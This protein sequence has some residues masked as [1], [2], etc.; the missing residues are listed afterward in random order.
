MSLPVANGDSGGNGLNLPFRPRARLLQLLG[1]ELIGSPRLA[2]FELVK[3]AYDADAETVRV[4]LKNIDSPRASIVV[5]DDGEGMTLET[6]R[7][8]WFVPGHDHRARQRA[9]LR[10][11]RRGRLPLGEKGVGRFAAHKLGDRIKLVTRAAGR[12]ECVVSVNWAALIRKKNLSDAK[13]RVTTRDPVVFR[14]TR[15]GTRITV[16][17][18]RESNWTRGEVRRLQRQITSIASPFTRRSDQFETRL[19]V[20]GH[21]DWVAGVPD[22]DALLSRAPWRFQFRFDKGRFDWKYQ[23]RG[24]TG[25]NL[26]PRHAERTKQPLLI[27]PER[28]MDEFGVDQGSRKTKPGRVVGDASLAEGIG[29]VEGRFY[30]FDRDRAVLSRLDESQLI[31]SY[32]DENGGI[33]VYRDGIRVYNYGESGDDWLGLDLRR[34]N[35]PTRNISRNIVI[36]AV[37][38][39]LADSHHL[40]EKTNR[41]GFVENLALGRLKQIVLGALTPMEVERHKDKDS[42]RELTGNVKF[43]KTKRIK[44][45]FKKL[46]TVARK[47]EMSDELKPLID[48]VEQEYNEFR[49]S[50]LRA[51]LSGMGLAMV[52]H[53]I[54]HGV[55]SLCNLI[56]EG[57]K[58]A[59][60]RLRARELAD[61]LGGFTDLLRK[62]TR[63]SNSLSHLIRRVRDINRVRFRKHCVRLECPV[64]ENDVLDVRSNFVFGLALGALNN[65]LDNAFYWL[66]THWPENAS[67]LPGRKIYMNVNLEL[68]DGPAIVV[69]DTGPGFTDEP[70]LLIRPFFSR[71]PEG[72][73]VGLYYAN[74]VMELGEGHLSFPNATQAD[75]PCEF[76][77][78]VVALVFPKQRKT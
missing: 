7:D 3:N 57:G 78:A 71:R 26:E 64:L 72:M 22:V 32:L 12:P 14:G 70:E 25:I 6:I 62:G 53:E 40:K 5:E 15:T 59:A 77:G 65:L 23:F 73:G 2:V 67:D 17:K 60:V 74:L 20:P 52:F 44:Q 51:G 21:E 27:R 35:N 34:V 1:D 47:S 66:K 50:M 56:E 42:I 58:R 69:A 76:D 63:Q 75:V 16:S 46:R 29:P 18:L 4:V 33:R 28:D 39:S 41:E 37:E 31:R 49:D 24:V 45:P 48:Q 54:E 11:T 9:D 61:V 30:V 38:L 68:A 55:R 43:P 13:V 36:G 10:R 8:I 19:E